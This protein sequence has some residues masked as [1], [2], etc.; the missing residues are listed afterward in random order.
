M[1]E[2]LFATNNQHKVEETQ[3]AI[4]DEIKI[5]SLKQAGIQVDIEEPFNTFTANASAKS[6]EIFN[7]TGKN[8]FSEDSGLEVKALMGEPG[9][10]SARYAGDQANAAQNVAKLLYKM[11]GMKDRHARFRTVISLQFNEQEYVF[12]GVCDGSIVC[13]PAGTRGFG[14][15]PVF[16]PV[17][18]MKTFA[19]MTLEEKSRFS[20]RKIACD[21]LVLF[22]QRWA[23]TGLR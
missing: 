10:K 13:Q 18:S 12:E 5:I 1:I 7:L 6:A 23:K 16:I 19:E 20:H 21:K 15:D 11:K 4:G 2:L 8:C 17:N 22:L 3:S 14:Y 9:V